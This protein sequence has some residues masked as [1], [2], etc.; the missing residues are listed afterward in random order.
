M[1]L[2][3]TMNGKVSHF[4]ELDNMKQ[5]TLFKEIIHRTEFTNNFFFCRAVWSYDHLLSIRKWMHWRNVQMLRWISMHHSRKVLRRSRGLRVCDMW[6]MILVNI[7]HI[8]YYML[9][10][11]DASD[12]VWFVRRL[13]RKKGFQCYGC[14]LPF[15]QAN[16]RE[17]ICHRGEIKLLPCGPKDSYLLSR[18]NS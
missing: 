6:N 16:N 3:R 8:N 5:L 10:C 2:Y 13:H 4:Y 7:L 9:N 12:E 11:R 14:F 18:K 15:S 17:K 1:T